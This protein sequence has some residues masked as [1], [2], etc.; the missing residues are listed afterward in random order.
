VSPAADAPSLAATLATGA[1]L[2]WSVA[3]PPGPINAEMIRRGLGRG[4]WSAY[5]VGLGACSADFLWALGVALGA[6]ALATLPG[7]RPALGA[8]SLALLLLLA[9]SFLAGAWRSWRRHRRGEP[10]PAGGA[11]D[12]ARG[13]YLLGF[14]MALA[15]PW[16]IAFWLAVMGGAQQG[17]HAAAAGAL[18]FGR[19]LLLAVAVVGAAACW[20]LIL[21]TGVR[22]GARFATPLWEIGTRAATGVLM[23]LFAG[24]L[25]HRLLGG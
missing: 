5:A 11:F 6:G 2:G 24:L 21:C 18:D 3:W 1:L 10:E 12:S 16:N 7:V 14:T 23:L 19:S 9:W 22:L 8:V 20:G 15:S 4:F 13:G 25:V 17:Q